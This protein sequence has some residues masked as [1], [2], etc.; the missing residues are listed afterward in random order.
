MYLNKTIRK[1]DLIFCC[2]LLLFIIGNVLSNTFFSSTLLFK[3]QWT[4]RI[5]IYGSILLLFVNEILFSKSLSNRIF[6]ILLFFSFI[7]LLMNLPVNSYRTRSAAMTPLFLFCARDI[8]KEK[9]LYTLYYSLLCLLLFVITFSKLGIIQDYL[10]FSSRGTR[11]YLGFLYSLYGPCILLGI[12]YC[13]LMLTEYNKSIIRLLFLFI[14]NIY[15]YIQT[16]SRLSFFLTF[17]TII[18]S[19]AIT[20]DTRLIRNKLLSILMCLSHPIAAISSIV[21]TAL[22]NPKN[23]LLSKLN[24]ALTGRLYY[25]N[26][27]IKSFGYSLFPKK[28]ELIGNGLD[29]YGLKTI[30]EYN[31]VDCLYLQSL[32]RYGLFLFIILLFFLTYAG[33]CAYKK[34]DYVFLLAFSI[35]SLQFMVDDLSILLFFNPI[36]LFTANIIF[37]HDNVQQ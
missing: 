35:C 13:A 18:F 14:L 20:F 30:G 31:Y 22:Y 36:L 11:H 32:L 23:L 29:V 34:R 17:L 10:E 7:F 4:M 12:S 8:K 25:G 3:S 19:F 6:T 21:L 28:I 5:M 26:K 37:E 27:A 16:I 1:K 9:L 15:L 2:T 24:S 33:Y